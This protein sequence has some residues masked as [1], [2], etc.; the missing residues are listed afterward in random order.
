MYLTFRKQWRSAYIHAGLV[1]TLSIDGFYVKKETYSHGENGT[2]KFHGYWYSNNAQD[3]GRGWF[4]CSIFTCRSDPGDS[5]L[6]TWEG[7]ATLSGKNYAFS[8]GQNFSGG[9]RYHRT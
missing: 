2:Y 3:H 4:K 8:A 6:I 9:G 1:W 7:I 5:V